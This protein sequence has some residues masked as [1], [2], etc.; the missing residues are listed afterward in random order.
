MKNLLTTLFI[1]LL[2]SGCASKEAHQQY[3]DGFKAASDGYYQAAQKPLIDLTLPAPDG[4]EY[5]LVVN[6]E[7]KP[8][9]PEQIKDSEWVG[10][11]QGLISVGGAVGGLAVVAGSAG[12]NTETV[13]GD[14]SGTSMENP[15]TT[16]TTTTTEMM[17]PEEVVPE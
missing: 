14:K 17:M 5:H 7:V 2:L 3:I 8:L 4:K 11:V 16:T 10:P 15:I 13:G 1:A 6:R 12:H 9:T